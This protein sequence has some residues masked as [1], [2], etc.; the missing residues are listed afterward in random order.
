M[1]AEV[2]GAGVDNEVDERSGLG[3]YTDGEGQGRLDAGRLDPALAA[4]RSEGGVLLPLF[5]SDQ[6]DEIAVAKQVCAGCALRAACL[7]GA[8]RRREPWGVWGGELFAEGSVLP[9]K[10]RRGRPPKQRNPEQ[11]T[12]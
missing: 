1:F 6:P 5:F 8:I 12:A 11:L 9:F 10:R 7:E 4:C 3:S 2:Q